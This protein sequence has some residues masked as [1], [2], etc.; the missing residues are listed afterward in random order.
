MR[1]PKYAK[2]RDENEPEIIAALKAVGCD[3]LQ[4]NDVDLIVGL[5]GRT[6]LVEVKHPKRASESRI[7]PIQKALRANWRGHYVIVTTV[8]QALQA[9]GL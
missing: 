1:Q 2:R 9:V 3:V 7:K 5:A 8:E 4:A 6:Y